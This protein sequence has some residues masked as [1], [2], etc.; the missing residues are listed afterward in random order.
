MIDRF[1]TIDRVLFW[2]EKKILIVGDLHLGYEESLQE[3]GW[4]VPQILLDE[5]MEIFKKIFKI[6]GK[7]EKIILL[8]DVKHN[9]AG[10][11]RQEMSDVYAV[12]GLFKK[13]LINDGE[14]IVTKGNHDNILESIVKN[15]RG[16]R[17]LDFYI[18]EDVLFFHGDTQSW[19]KIG[20]DVFDEKI[21][22]I[23]TGHYH[24]AILVEEGDKRERYKCFVFGKEKKLKKNMIVVPSFFTLVEGTDI[25]GG[26]EG[27]DL[28]NIKVFAVSPDGSVYDFSGMKG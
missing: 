28:K 16:V 17:L 4:T 3:Q 24:P 2:K 21:K 5:T 18:F 20:L 22:L 15:F 10:V 8:G 19:E 23:V 13:N 12:F 11:L 6:A 27:M 7:V 14:I 25:S 1:E 26:F 9:F